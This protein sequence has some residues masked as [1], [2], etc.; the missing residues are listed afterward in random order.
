MALVIDIIEIIA[1]Q[2]KFNVMSVSFSHNETLIEVTM[3]D[4]I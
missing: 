3:N 4:T 2:I 1:R